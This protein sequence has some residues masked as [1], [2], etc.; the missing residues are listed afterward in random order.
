V[1]ILRPQ[2]HF[3]RR[4]FA[5]RT[6]GG[7]LPAL[8]AGVLFCAIGAAQSDQ[9]S[10]Y[11]VKAA[12]LFN[13]TKF[14]EWPDGSFEDA[15]APIVIGIIG[16]DPFGDGLIR[17]VAGQK[18]QG[19]AIVIIKYRRGDDLRRCHILFISASERQHSA[20]ILV[21]LKD[22]SVLTVSDLDGFAA[23]GGVMQFVMEENRVR[24]VVNLDAATQGKLRVSAKLLALAQVVNH[25][26]AAR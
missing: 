9:P 14:V 17:I 11:E 1:D 15:H 18:V 23:A 24:F 20:Q 6:A 12:F 4:R 26:Q 21:G 13:F 10:E 7:F 19:R 3:L 22:A 16:D 5:L 8:A 25:G 2:P